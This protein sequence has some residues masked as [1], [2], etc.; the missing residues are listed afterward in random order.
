MSL[1][2]QTV[3]LIRMADCHLPNTYRWLHD[4]AELRRQVDCLEAPTE[5]GNQAYWRANWQNSRREDYA[6]VAIADNR[7]IG[8]CGLCD[9]DA[10]RKKA[11]LWIYLGDSYGEGT[12]T[13][14]V[15][16][17]LT[18]AFGALELDRVYLRVVASNPRALR[19]YQKLG[20]VEEGVSRQDTIADGCPVDAICMSMLKSEYRGNPENR[21][22][23]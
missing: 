5:E 8:N 13:A 22:C 21:A 6:I 7:H 18:R 20:F 14:A 3:L 11:Q 19:F 1:P 10:S 15:D 23:R 12:G 4:S 17:L 2:E 9:I 16:Q